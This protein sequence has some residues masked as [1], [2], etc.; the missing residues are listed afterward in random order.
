MAAEIFRPNKFAMAHS[1]DVMIVVP[2]GIEIP[3][4]LP[5]ML[6]EKGFSQRDLVIGDVKG[7]LDS[8]AREK[9]LWIS[10][11]ITG[12]W[13][14]VPDRSLREYGVY[15]LQPSRPLN[16]ETLLTRV[17][18]A[19]YLDLGMEEE[20]MRWVYHMGSDGNPAPVVLDHTVAKWMSSYP[21]LYLRGE[22]FP[23]LREERTR[24]EGC[25]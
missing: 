22:Y 6:K 25:R 5:T 2:E 20:W 4:D 7:H 15:R 9:I 13:E 19:K 21:Y 24:G 16:A 18:D 17:P 1:N 14:V 23:R 3:E 10:D 8:K 12:E 11:N